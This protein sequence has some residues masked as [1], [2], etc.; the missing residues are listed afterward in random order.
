MS[1]TDDFNYA[2]EQT[3][4]LVPPELRLNTFGTSVLNYYLITEDMDAVNLVWVREGSIEAARPQI[5]TPG[6]MAK[7]M[8]EGFGEQAA[9][10]AAAVSANPQRFAFL[11]YGFTVKKNDLRV[12]EAH[13]PV[14]AVI[15][16]VKAA[17]AAKADPLSAVIKGV[18]DAWE[19]CLLKFT[20]D[21][22]AASGGQNLRDLRDRGL[23]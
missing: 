16:Q 14:D 1:A 21:L 2:L 8:L 12:Y 19:V 17:V 5:I 7:L 20:L 9:R 18:D 6:N 11:K 10:L 3:E 23:L 22:A 4:V 13:E 15:A